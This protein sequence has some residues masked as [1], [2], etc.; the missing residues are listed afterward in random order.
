MDQSFSKIKTVTAAMKNNFSLVYGYYALGFYTGLL[1][2]RFCLYKSVS[3]ISGKMTM[4]F[5]NT[6]GPLKPFIYKGKN[7]EIIRNLHS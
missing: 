7:G 4:V 3:N 1:L 5:S 2:P 6:P